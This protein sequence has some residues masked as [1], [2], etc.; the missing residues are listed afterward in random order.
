MT[1]YDILIGVIDKASYKRALDN[2]NN[3]ELDALLAKDWK[4][5]HEIDK[6][7]DELMKFCAEKYAD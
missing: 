4:A 3:K 5:V 2:L 6:Q 1:C 7:R